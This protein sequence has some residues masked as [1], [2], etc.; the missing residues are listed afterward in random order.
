[1]LRGL[2]F[3]SHAVGTA[4]FPGL[5]LAEGIG[6]AAP[7]G[8]F[9]AAAV[10]AVAVAA[11]SGRRR[12]GYDSLTAL[13]LVGCLALG[14][15]LASDVF[16]S[17]A[18]VDT[19]LFGSLLLIDGGDIALAAGASALAIAGSLLLGP[20]WLVTG[21]DPDGAQALGVRSRAPELALLLL[22]AAGTTAA[23]T[24]TGALLTTAIFVVP[25]ATTRLFVHRVPAWQ[26]ATVGLLAAEGLA[27]VL[28]ADATNTPPG[29]AIAVIS[30]GVFALAAIARVAPRRAAAAAAAA[31]VA[32]AGCG[33]EDASGGKPGAVE[34]VATTTQ[35]ADFV[36]AV[37]GPD[38]KLT[39]ILEPNTDAHDYEPRPDDVKATAR[40]KLAFA[41]GLGLDK[42]MADVVDDSGASLEQVE[43]GMSVPVR[44]HGDPHWWHDPRN[45]EAAVKDVA[46]TLGRADPSKKAAFDRNARAYLAKL[47]TLDRGIARCFAAVPEDRRKLV[48][49]HDAFD[50]FTERYGIRVVGAVIP[51][52]TTQAQPSAGDLAEL[53]RLIREEGVRAVYPESSVNPRLAEAIAE[54]TGATA[55]YTLYGDS[56][57]PKGSSGATYLTMERANADA[58]VR[59]FTGGKRGCEIDGIG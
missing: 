56:L 5:V 51:S 26:A 42:W 23:L 22:V 37:G 18:S 32:L 7:L 21:F 39:Q 17:G 24:A 13:V 12:T 27:G 55:K 46:E 19:L 41:S 44:R 35:V 36:R 43:L 16:H 31:L 40:A 10:F 50:Y 38:V 11:L 47:R 57:G 3:F 9:A 14:V 29:A 8:G 53:S 58:M 28:L 4:A 59:G 49:D 30:G 54:Q 15:V 20:R 48:T 45:A 1:M 6:F 2:A 33:T 34:V 25:A 52:Q